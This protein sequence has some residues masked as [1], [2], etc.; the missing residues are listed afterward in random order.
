[1]IFFIYTF[2]SVFTYTTII[3]IIIISINV[4]EVIAN[5]NVDFP[6]CSLLLF[7]EEFDVLD[8]FNLNFKKLY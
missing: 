5:I 6:N 2:S 1:M 3:N 7:I 4:I 8:I